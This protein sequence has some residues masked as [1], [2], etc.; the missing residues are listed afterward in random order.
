MYLSGNLLNFLLKKKQQTN[1]KIS[2]FYVHVHD[3]YKNAIEKFVR[4]VQH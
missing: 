3:A 2:S 1:K 4:L